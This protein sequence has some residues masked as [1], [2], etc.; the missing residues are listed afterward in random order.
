[1]HGEQQLACPS[2]GCTLQGLNHPGCT[3]A[4]GLAWSW[5]RERKGTRQTG[6]LLI[7][8]SLVSNYNLSTSSTLPRDLPL[9]GVT[10]CPGKPQGMTFPPLR[11]ILVLQSLPAPTSLLLTPQHR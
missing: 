1:M 6:D 4:G 9:P 11:S 8:F 10:L 5:A 3:E 7:A 2:S